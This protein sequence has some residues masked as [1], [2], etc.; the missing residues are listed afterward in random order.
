MS[1]EI[2]RLLTV[3]DYYPQWGSELASHMLAIHREE[4][5]RRQDFENVFDQ[6]FLNALFDG[7]NDKPPAFATVAPAI[8]DTRLPSLTNSGI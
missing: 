3:S 6:H 1:F 7:L 5:S 4:E 8:F 2:V